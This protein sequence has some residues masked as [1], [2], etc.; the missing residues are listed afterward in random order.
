MLA[1]DHDGFPSGAASQRTWA[2]PPP[3]G[4]FGYRPN[5]FNAAF[6]ISGVGVR[7]TPVTVPVTLFIRYTR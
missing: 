5:T 2:G 4:I 6:I 7:N 3:I 1:P